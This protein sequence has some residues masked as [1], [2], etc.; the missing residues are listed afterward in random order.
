MIYISAVN[1]YKPTYQF[2]D[3]EDKSDSKSVDG[4]IISLVLATIL[5]IN[6][7]LFLVNTAFYSP[8]FATWVVRDKTL[9]S[10]SA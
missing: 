1:N 10:I 4:K 2:P 5:F 3:D 8:G 7:A 9:A 6:K